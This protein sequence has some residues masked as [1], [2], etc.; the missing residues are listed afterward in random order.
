VYQQTLI[1]NLDEILPLADEDFDLVVSVGVFSYVQRFDTLFD[2]ILRV[3]RPGAMC[4]FTHRQDLWDPDV[5]GC[6]TE[7][8][9]R[10]RN[11]KWEL[12]SEGT[13]EDYMPRNPH[14]DQRALKV[15]LL[16]FRK[17]PAE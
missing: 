8:L 17:L 1:A 3:S 7:A 6:R 14:D 12:I 10:V 4:I 16:A 5:R 11:L 9:K 15:R 13:P 2:E